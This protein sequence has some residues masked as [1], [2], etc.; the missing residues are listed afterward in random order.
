MGLIGGLAQVCARRSCCTL[1]LMIMMAV[2]YLFPAS[3]VMT[4]PLNDPR[5][6]I[7][8]GWDW[9]LPPSAPL[10]N[11]WALACWTFPHLVTL[12]L[13]FLAA[14]I[15]TIEVIVIGLL[16]LCQSMRNRA[17]DLANPK[18]FLQDKM[19]L[20]EYLTTLACCRVLAAANSTSKPLWQ[21]PQGLKTLSC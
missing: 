15:C 4:V 21:V 10:Q 17:Q 20:Q 8:S 9:M 11:C 13:D 16:A 6:F 19:L 18:M 5:S 2:C 3:R 1:R 14:C 7:A 12:S